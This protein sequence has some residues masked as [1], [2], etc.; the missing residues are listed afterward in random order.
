MSTPILWYKPVG[1]VPDAW[2][3]GG[4]VGVWRLCGIKLLAVQTLG[5]IRLE[6]GVHM[7]R[8]ELAGSISFYETEE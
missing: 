8:L 5:I 7:L 3:W 6:L 1:Q 4:H 2:T